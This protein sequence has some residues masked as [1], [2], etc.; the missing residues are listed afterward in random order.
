MST[1][2]SR[3]IIGISALVS[4][5]LA[6]S[7][8]AD[9]QGGTDGS[10]MIAATGGVPAID[11]VVPTPGNPGVP[12]RFGNVLPK[13][14][15]VTL[16]GR[17]L[18]SGSDYA[19]DYASGVVYLYRTAREGESV[20]VEYRYD[21]TKSPVSS[22]SMMGLPATSLSLAPGMGV[23]LG[24]GVTERTAD[25]KVLRSNLF[26]TNNDLKLG[27]ASLTGVYMVGQRSNVG[28]ASG[29]N[30]NAD[31][32]G[33]ASSETGDSSFLVQSF[34]L[35][36]A[37]GS[38]T[39]DRQDISKNFVGFSA[40]RGGS[41]DDKRLE[42]LAKEKGLVRGGMALR[43][44]KM[45]G[46]AFTYGQRDV[47]DG[48]GGI[49]WREYGYASGGFKF[50]ANTRRVDNTFTRFN[51]LAEADRDQ[52]AREK[53]LERGSYAGEFKSKTSAFS[54]AS[55]TVAENATGKGATRREAKI[56]TSR[57][58]LD[59]GDQT[60]DSGFNRFD[61]LLGQE[62]AQWGLEAG[63]HRQWLGLRAD[64]MLGMNFAFR[65]ENVGGEKGEFVADSL[66][67]R[68]GTWSLEHVGKS[69]GKGFDRLGALSNA[70]LTNHANDI[71]AMYNGRPFASDIAANGGDA[72]ALKSATGLSRTFDKLTAA[73]VKGLSVEATQLRVDGAKDGSTVQTL[74]L[75]GKNAAFKFRTLN[76]GEN[77]GEITA[78][79]GFERARLGELKGLSR[80]DMQ[81]DM[82]LAPKANLS[83]ATMSANV[84]KSGAER[85]RVAYSD[86]RLQFTA[87]V[88]KVDKDFAGVQSLVDEE[89]DALASLAGYESRELALNWQ[90]FKN[91]RL[92]YGTTSGGNPLDDR[93]RAANNFAFDWQTDPSMRV[94]YQAKSRSESGLVGSQ[95]KTIFA[96]SVERLGVSKRFG[97]AAAIEYITETRNYDGTDAKTP[98]SRLTSLALEARVSPSTTIKT[99]RADTD[100][101][102]GNRESV[103][104]NSIQTTLTPRLGVSVSDTKIARTG[105]DKKDETKRDYG[106]WVDFGKGVRLSYG[107]VRSLIGEN[108]G[109][110]TTTLNFGQN[111]ART[112]AANVGKAGTANVNGTEVGFGSAGSTWDDQEG[113]VQSFNNLRLKTT[114]PFGF[115]WMKGCSLLLDMDTA[116]DKSVWIR[117]NQRYAFTGNIG[118]SSLG[119]EYRGQTDPSGERAADRTLSFKTDPKAK[120]PIS[121][122]VSYK[123]RTLPTGDGIAIRDYSVTARPTKRIEVT[124]QIQTNPETPRPDALLGSIPRGDRLNRWKVDYKGAD[125]T[126]GGTWE[127]LF[128]D[129]N[130]KG[131]TTAGINLSL[132]TSSGSPFSVFYGIETHDDGND[133]RAIGRYSISFDQR[134]GPNQT[135][136]MF[137]GNL[138]YAGSTK[139]DESMKDDDW[140]VR[141]NYQLRF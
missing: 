140:T 33:D 127:E 101:S 103:S 94:S 114:K 88:R 112:D 85:T 76:V 106:M 80:R 29:F 32:G 99:V 20:V 30:F 49:D 34:R 83:I 21:R 55:N 46:G 126:F 141:L 116:S 87:N 97:Q 135:L 75:T 12:L 6:A 68:G 57:F 23:S 71:A 40:L 98:D 100:F 15:R 7:A 37:G 53:G 67:V 36:V 5:S 16:G 73:P 128:N 124:N 107:Y 133:R 56:D 89:R 102:D 22:A 58:G 25:G 28:V 35:G 109:A 65:R 96:Q 111:A 113:R 64:K 105:E 139:R 66:S 13:S 59:F 24:L 120:A 72:N 137:L 63:L 108:A 50:S 11:S 70:E 74:A 4:L 10:P 119:F 77:F 115:L 52:I 38:L 19:M 78:L 61:S 51:D 39:V 62:K 69:A 92:E 44:A 54:F 17:V 27:A 47:T 18:Q 14:E 110:S 136:S 125:F 129:G 41:L 134:P 118:G 90:A 31:K 48:K 3:A 91:L 60:V 2:K 132:F 8:A 104:T 9:Q 121:A 117:E 84:G 79:M 86:P 95:L 93:E 43:D 131:A 138:S 1:R 42:Q 122:A 45:L 130:S 26:G 82:K 81:F 123:Q